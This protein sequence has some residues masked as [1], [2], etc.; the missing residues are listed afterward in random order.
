MITKACGNCG[1]SFNTYPSIDKK[2]CS[3][4]CSRALIK[5]ET[6]KR[7]SRVCT[8]CGEI[9]LPKHTKS[10][11]LFCSY[12]C[13]GL[14]QRHE[15]VDRQGYWYIRVDDHPRRP[16]TGYVPE[17]TLVM[18]RHIGRYLKDGEVVHHVNHDRKDNRIENLQIMSDA[19][20]RAHHMLEAIDSGK[21]NTKKQRQKSAER[22]RSSNPC[23]TARRGPDGR[24]IK[25]L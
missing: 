22:M 12:K 25:E 24:F 11:N 15:R 10:P 23:R 17:H 3:D 18:E 19:E 21:V 2:S 14:S 9:F 8:F 1:K 4:P 5:K 16:S 7:N 20:H 6:R 13:R